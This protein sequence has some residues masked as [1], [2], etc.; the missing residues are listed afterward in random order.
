MASPEI[1]RLPLE[2]LQ[3]IVGCLHDCHPRSLKNFAL[4]SKACLAAARVYLYR[5]VHIEVGSPEKLVLDVGRQLSHLELRH[6]LTYPRKVVVS[7]ILARDSPDA[8]E[9]LVRLVRTLTAVSDFEYSCHTRLPPCVLAAIHE[10]LPRCRLHL[11]SLLFEGSTDDVLD[12]HELALASSPCLHSIRVVA[13]NFGREI[14]DLNNGTLPPLPP[15]LVAEY[16]DF[17]SIMTQDMVAGLAPN[18]KSVKLAHGHERQLDEGSPPPFRRTLDGNVSSPGLGKLAFLDLSCM[19]PAPDYLEAWAS[20]T[21]FTLLRELRLTILNPGDGI[22]TRAAQR[23][24]F[25]S[26]NRFTVQFRMALASPE[27]VTDDVLAFLRCLP[28]LEGLTLSM[29][30][31]PAI[32][33]CILHRFG[34]SLRDLVLEDAEKAIRHTSLSRHVISRIADNCP[35]LEKLQVSVPRSRSDGREVELYR[36]FG[37]M[38]R[39]KQLTLHNV[40]DANISDEAEERIVRDAN[41]FGTL[42]LGD[43]SPPDP[44]NTCVVDLLLNAAMDRTLA[45]SIW[46]IINMAKQGVPLEKLSLTPYLSSWISNDNTDAGI[47]LADLLWRMGSHFVLKRRA[48]KDDPRVIVSDKRRFLRETLD[49]M[50]REREAR[51][52]HPDPNELL[53]F[54]TWPVMKAF[55]QLWPPKQGS[56]D[57]R[58]DWESEPL[59]FDPPDDWESEPLMA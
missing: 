45:L 38:R 48:N 42:V 25:P 59:I 24:S 15:Y 41:P 47:G 13:R 26:L 19:N 5:E 2:A 34:G 18:L 23:C 4:A 58:D 9:P 22:F 35:L 10:F 37:R 52:P 39:L 55:R 30:L 8:W 12:P 11:L 44:S 36:T 1:L 6:A 21:D 56:V 53:R 20:L 7:G 46:D 43:I 40:V 3:Y 54:P 50:N 57:W 17:N 27:N 14:D 28:P 29:P 49:I 16:S 31:N 51:G 32:L 33:D